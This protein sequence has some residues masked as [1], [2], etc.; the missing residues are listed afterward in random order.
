MI[1]EAIEFWEPKGWPRSCEVRGPI[2]EGSGG[3]QDF[4]SLRG[5]QE[6]RR[7]RDLVQEFRESSGFQESKEAARRP[8]GQ[9]T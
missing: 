9:G 1:Q 3:Y 5:G 8:L 4:R 6:A 7:S 2:A